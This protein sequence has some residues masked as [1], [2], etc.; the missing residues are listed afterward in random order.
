MAIDTTG[1]W[2]TGTDAVDLAEYI[3]EFSG[4]GRGY[5]AERVIPCVCGHCGG[6]RFR[7]AVDDEAGT[8]CRTCVG[9]GGTAFIADSAEANAARYV[10]ESEPE[11]CAC[12]CGGEEFEAAVGFALRGNGEVKWIYVGMRCVADGVLGVCADWKISY[13]PTGHLFG[14]V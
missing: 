12:P 11:E 3:G 7:I 5:P 2:W 10:D 1:E 8:A 13:S 9:C 14:Q 4:A 6:R